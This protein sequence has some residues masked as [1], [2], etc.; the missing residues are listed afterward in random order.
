MVKHMVSL[1]HETPGPCAADLPRSIVKP[2][3]AELCR[4]LGIE[5]GNTW[6]L[7]VSQEGILQFTRPLTETEKSRYLAQR[8]AAGSSKKYLPQKPRKALY[9]VTS[10]DKR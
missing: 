9:K 5:P 7:E 4:R 6:V 10:R 8:L 2:Q 3:F 1:G